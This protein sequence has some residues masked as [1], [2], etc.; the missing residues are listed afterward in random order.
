MASLDELKTLIAR[1]EGWNVSGSVAQRNRNP[2]NLR[3]AGQSGA[4][5]QNQGYAVFDSV[6]AGWAALERQ[7]AL[8]ASRGLT[9]EEFTYKYAPPSENQTRDYLKFLT[10]ELG[11]TASTPLNSLGI[12]AAP[13]EAPAGYSLASSIIPNLEGIP[14]WVWLAGLGVVAVA[15]IAR[16]D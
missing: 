14:V 3:Y 2:G 6:E 7:I 5:G 1:M 8:D 15:F 16:R 10:S 9:L 12:Q 11:V 4:V 13:S